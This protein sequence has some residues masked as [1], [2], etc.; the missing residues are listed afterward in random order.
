MKKIY[1]A[2]EVIETTMVVESIVAQSA[3]VSSERGEG[4]GS[5]DIKRQDRGDWENIWNN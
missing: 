2:P 3:G 1:Q 5:A 4:T